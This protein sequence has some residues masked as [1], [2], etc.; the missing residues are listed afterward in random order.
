[1][2]QSPDVANGDQQRNLPGP[3]EEYGEQPDVTKVVAQGE[4]E[5]YFNSQSINFKVLLPKHE[6]LF[7][8]MPF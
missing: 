2:S 1:M 5:Q 7:Y 8:Y 3:P 4:K 6:E